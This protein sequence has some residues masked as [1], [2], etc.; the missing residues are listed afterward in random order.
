M[1]S[2]ILSRRCPKLPWSDAS[3]SGARLDASPGPH[4]SRPGHNCI[5]LVLPIDADAASPDGCDGECHAD[6]H[7]SLVR[8]LLKCTETQ[9][10]EERGYKQEGKWLLALC[11]L[12]RRER[13]VQRQ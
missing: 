7:E 5:A 2:V 1:L 11:A 13:E 8:W 3:P 9:G 12:D 6:H 10:G 4:G